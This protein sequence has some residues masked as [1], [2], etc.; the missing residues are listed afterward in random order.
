[1]ERATRLGAAAERWADALAVTLVPDY[2]IALESA[3]ARARAD[4]G[5]AAYEAAWTEGDTMSTDQAVAYALDE[6]EAH[7]MSSDGPLSPREREVAGLV[8]RGLT[9]RQLAHELVISTRTADHH[10]ANIL[11]KLGLATRAQI[12][13][14]VERMG[15]PNR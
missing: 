7:E 2:R 13:G 10:V 11:A 9:N 4:L 14:W 6:A 1:M 12:A 5:E 8:A 3:L 15:I